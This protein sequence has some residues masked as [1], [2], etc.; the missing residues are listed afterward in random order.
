MDITD[1]W[2]PQPGV[3]LPPVQ[4]AKADAILA[5]LVSDRGAPTLE[6]YRRVYLSIGV[7]WPGD[8]EIRR[9]YPVADAAFGG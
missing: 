7:A 6:H 5:G 2:E 8:D 1:T 3:P 9:V 4:G